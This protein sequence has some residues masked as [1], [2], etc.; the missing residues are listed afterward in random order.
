MR[1]TDAEIDALFD[2]AFAD[3]DRK[4][5]ALEQG[6]G[7]GGHA[8]WR[9]DLT[10]PEVLFLDG[11]DQPAV[12][13]GLLVVGTLGGGVWQ[14]AWANQ[15]LPERVREPSAALKSYAQ[16]TGLVVFNEA[17][18]TSSEDQAWMTTALA[19]RHFGADGG[20]RIPGG[21]ADV[22]ALLL[23]PLRLGAG[24]VASG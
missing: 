20:Y 12:R 4:Q 21:K 3:F 6:F 1:M 11:E 23:N 2:E 24:A 13:C 22:Y 5:D 15:Q 18:W 16:S 8:R 9:A 14:W 10:V 17:R 7:I 19:C